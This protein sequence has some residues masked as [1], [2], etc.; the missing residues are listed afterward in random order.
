M[1]RGLVSGSR[2]HATHFEDL[3]EKQRTKLN[4][5]VD[6]ESYSKTF[7]DSKI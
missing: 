3:D 2:A 5:L 7:L 1:I 4:K 6:D